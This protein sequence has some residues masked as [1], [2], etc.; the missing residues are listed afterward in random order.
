MPLHRAVRGYGRLSGHLLP[1]GGGG[2]GQRPGGR[3]RHACYRAEVYPSLRCGELGM[4]GVRELVGEF[5]QTLL[6]SHA[7]LGDNFLIFA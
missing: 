6:R 4:M 5:E 7:V 2:R 1:G 3:R